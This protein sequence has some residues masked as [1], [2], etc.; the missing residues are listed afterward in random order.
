MLLAH[1]AVHVRTRATHPTH[2]HTAAYDAA[3]AAATAAAA[4]AT[5]V[6]FSDGTWVG[7]S[8]FAV[9]GGGATA[10]IADRA[11]FDTT[12]STLFQYGIHVAFFGSLY[13]GSNGSPFKKCIQCSNLLLSGRSLCHN[14]GCLRD[15]HKGV[16]REM[17]RGVCGGGEQEIS[18]GE[19]RKNE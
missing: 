11:D 17:E 4:T 9:S 18:R 3:S 1:C 6:D 19:E 7:I 2:T 8:F 14:L 10:N 16:L 13:R 15:T 5:A 12:P